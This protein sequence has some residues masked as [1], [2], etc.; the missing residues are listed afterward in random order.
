MPSGHF[1]ELTETSFGK[2]LSLEKQ[3]PVGSSCRLDTL[4]HHGRSS[5][6][7]KLSKERSCIVVN[8]T[9]VTNKPDR[10]S[11]SALFGI[12]FGKNRR[13]LKHLSL[14]QTHNKSVNSKNNRQHTLEK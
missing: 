13:Y 10:I 4:V 3:K 2:C 1:L 11:V 14:Q 8:V 5:V 6:R 12:D 9:L 7:L